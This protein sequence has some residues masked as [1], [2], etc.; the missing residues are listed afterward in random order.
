MTAS[1]PSTPWLLLLLSLFFFFFTKGSL[2]VS[3]LEP[4]NRKPS[5]IR[6]TRGPVIAPASLPLK[7]KLCR[8]GVISIQLFVN[9]RRGPLLLLLLLLL[10][11]G[12]L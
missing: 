10:L 5:L 7:S 4:F 9:V 11:L 8:V 3:V 2:G 12:C 1:A 6:N